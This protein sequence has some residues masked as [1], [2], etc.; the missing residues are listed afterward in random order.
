[1][2]LRRFFDMAQSVYHR[3]DEEAKAIV[4]AMEHPQ[5]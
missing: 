5:S 3:L 2:S 4:E 1:M